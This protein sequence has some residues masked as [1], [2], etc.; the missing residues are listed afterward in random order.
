MSVKKTVCGITYAPKAEVEKFRQALK[1]MNMTLAAF[2][3]LVAVEEGGEHESDENNIAD[4]VKRSFS[5]NLNSQRLKQY[6]QYLSQDDR[7]NKTQLTILPNASGYL[8]NSKYS[9]DI[10]KAFKS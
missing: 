3:E 9:Q 7:F 4:K 8:N 2:C 1:D 6:W 5:R 10:I